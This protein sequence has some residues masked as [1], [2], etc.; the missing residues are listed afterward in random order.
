MAVARAFPYLRYDTDTVGDPGRLL[1]PPY[2]VVDDAGR[3][4]LAAASPHQSIL[5]ELPEG[6]DPA[7]AATLLRTWR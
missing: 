2:D 5:V 4:R 1:A 6:G 7:N 3:A